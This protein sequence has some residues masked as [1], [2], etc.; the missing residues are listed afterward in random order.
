M[1]KL[2]RVN[3]LPFLGLALDFQREPLTFVRDLWNKH[4]DLVEFV[5]AGQRMFFVNRPEFIHHI[6]L[7]NQKNY[8][9]RNMMYHEMQILFRQATSVVDGDRWKKGHQLIQPT[10]SFKRVEEMSGVM[11]ECIG[12][13][14]VKWAEKAESH[15]IANFSEDIHRLTLDIIVRTMFGGA[16]EGKEEQVSQWFRVLLDTI[17]SRILSPV[18]LP[19]WAPTPANLRYRSAIAK[20]DSLI[21]DMIDSKLKSAPGGDFQDMLAQWI[22]AG[23]T[24]PSG[25]SSPETLRDEVI[26]IFVAAHGSTAVFLSWTFYHLATHPEVQEKVFAEVSAAIGDRTPIYGDLPEFTYTRQVIEESMRITPPGW[27]ISR[28]TIGEDRLGETVIPPRSMMLVSP[29]LIH[30]HPEFWPEPEKFDPDRFSEANQERV[31]KA[32]KEFSYIPFSGGPRVCTG[33]NMAMVECL[34][35]VSMTIRKFRVSMKPGHRVIPEGGFTLGL[36]GGLLVNLERR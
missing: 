32:A 2:A 30:H 31:E 34:L 17:V 26:G 9:K 33:K 18:N 23:K 21:Y 35:I 13:T 14:L 16:I 36:G 3:G 7:R 12:Q 5:V 25:Q 19:L 22:E 6:L 15:S 10:F 29:Y 20:L 24:A 27:I 28:S 4:G 11:V 1:T 8:D